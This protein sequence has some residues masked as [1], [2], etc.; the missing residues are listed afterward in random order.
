MI[1]FQIKKLARSVQV[2]FPWL[3]DA[4]FAAHHWYHRAAGRLFQAEY[5]GLGCFDWEGQLLLD[6]GANRGQSTVAFENAVPRR[7]QFRASAAEAE[8][9]ARRNRGVEWR[10]GDAGAASPGNP[11]GLSVGC[12]DRAAR[13]IRL[14]HLRLSR[15]TVSCGPDRPTLHLVPA[16]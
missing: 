15:R 5:G 4:K 16:R 10:R 14:P 13:G 6:I 7:L 1:G 3:P 9:A 8:C 12:A 11:F 2:F